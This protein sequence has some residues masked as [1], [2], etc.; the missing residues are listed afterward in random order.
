MGTMADFDW[1]RAR[2]ECSLPK[3][4]ERLFAGA[5]SDVDA[6]NGVARET[7]EGLSFEAS[8]DGN[9]ILVTRGGSEKIRLVK[10]TLAANSIDIE[11]EGSELIA[12]PGLNPAGNCTLMVNGAELE[13][14]QVRRTALER[15]FFGV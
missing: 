1:V 10:F 2:S 9:R 12:T 5:Q 8:R 15:L 6:R 11:G 14:W 7:R 3:I 13:L 4:F